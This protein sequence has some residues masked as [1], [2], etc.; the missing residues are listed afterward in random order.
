[1][2][3]VATAFNTMADDLKASQ[4]QRRDMVADIAH[5]LRTPLAALQAQLQGISGRHQRDYR[6]PSQRAKDALRGIAR[7]ITPWLWL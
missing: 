7:R 4:A 2:R 6:S 1:M 5:E 3:E